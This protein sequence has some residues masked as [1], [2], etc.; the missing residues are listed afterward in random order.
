MRKLLAFFFVL[1]T[2]MVA[3]PV[4]NATPSGLLQTRP[5]AGIQ[6]S[7]FNV[8]NANSHKCLEIEN[9]SG[10]DGARAQQWSC[11]GQGGALW[12]QKWLDNVRF[13]LVNVSGK[14]LEIQNSSGDDGARAQQWTCN[15]QPGSI[16]Y[17]LK[18]PGGDGLELV[19]EGGRKCLEIQN[20]RTDDGARAQ[21]WGCVAI[22]TMKWY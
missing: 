15:G 17:T 10:D 9:S 1:F 4:A 8:R 18:V 12:R 2:A 3:A 7:L 5:E 21:Q 19:N 6:A 20:S 22:P 11:N 16:W 14:C 13:Y